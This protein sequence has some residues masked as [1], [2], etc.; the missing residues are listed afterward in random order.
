VTATLY[1]LLGLD[2]GTGVAASVIFGLVGLA[3]ATP[4]LIVLALPSRRRT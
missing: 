4:G 3:A 2:A 1:S